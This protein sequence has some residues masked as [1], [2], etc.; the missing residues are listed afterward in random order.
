M[1]KNP[2]PN[3]NASVHGDFLNEAGQITR[4]FKHSYLTD[5]EDKKQ[6]GA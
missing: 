4:P 6:T 1:N 5:L 3:I 2:T